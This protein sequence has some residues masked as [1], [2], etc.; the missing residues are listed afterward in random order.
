MNNNDI[1]RRIRYIFDF[2]DTKMIKV[3]RLADARVTRERVSD[4]LKKEDN[5]A[6]REL[7]DEMLAMFLD[8]LISEKRG[9]KNG[10]MRAAIHTTRFYSRR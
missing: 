1:L 2:N 7:N 9:Q 10:S 5:P 6:Y 8:G 4:W 3:F